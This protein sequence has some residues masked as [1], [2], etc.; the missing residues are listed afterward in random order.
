M[1]GCGAFATQLGFVVAYNA[2]VYSLMAANICVKA[3]CMHAQRQQHAQWQQQPNTQ[4]H[5]LITQSAKHMLIQG[6]EKPYQAMQL[7]L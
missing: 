5:S 1:L 3:A 2:P 4:Q 7:F 6:S